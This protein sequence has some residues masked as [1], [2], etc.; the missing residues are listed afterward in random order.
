MLEIS[1]GSTSY[2]VSRVKS[3][4][5]LT[6]WIEVRFKKTISICKAVLGFGISDGWPGFLL[7]CPHLA[8]GPLASVLWGN[9]FLFIGG[10]VCASVHTYACVGVSVKE[11]RGER[12]IYFSSCISP[13]SQE[14][15]WTPNPGRKT[16]SMVWHLEVYWLEWKNCQFQNVKS[17]WEIRCF[18]QT[19]LHS[20][21]WLKKKK[22]KSCLVVLLI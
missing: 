21:S 1:S 3:G 16:P 13:A 22:K 17:H 9:Q 10:C 2:N 8:E 12:E 20:D 15:P 18:L 7:T 4:R 6:R 11:N 5:F 19:F 14:G